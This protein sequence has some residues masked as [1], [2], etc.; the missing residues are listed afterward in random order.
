MPLAP[1]GMVNEWAVP[2]NVKV[3]RFENEMMEHFFSMEQ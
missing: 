3:A 1:E 2:A